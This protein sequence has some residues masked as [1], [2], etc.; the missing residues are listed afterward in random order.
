MSCY[1]I[2]PA[3]DD[4]HL[5][6]FCQLLEVLQLVV[7]LLQLRPHR[8]RLVLRLL[9]AR[10][11]QRLRA[12]AVSSFNLHQHLRIMQRRPARRWV[13]PLLIRTDRNIVTAAMRKSVSDVHTALSIV[14]AQRWMRTSVRT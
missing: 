11:Q 12:G 6:I 10:P 5:R 8:R 1:T 7:R 3:R 9:V 2:Y 4:T 13:L 14:F